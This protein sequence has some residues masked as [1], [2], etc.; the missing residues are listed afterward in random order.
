M[1]TKIKAIAQEYAHRVW[2]EKDLRAIDDLLAKALI[3]HSPLGDYYGPEAMRTVVQSWLT[4]FPDL[5]VTNSHIVCENDLVVMQWKAHGTHLGEFKGRKPTGK[6]IAYPG[7]TIYQIKQDKI[8]EYWAYID[9][10][11]LLAQL[12]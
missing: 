4:A 1:Q 12:E 3:I 5:A 2:D 8:A 11:Y 10:Q 9:M 7:V 6:Q